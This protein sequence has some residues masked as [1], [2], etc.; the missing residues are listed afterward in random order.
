MTKLF[1]YDFDDQVRHHL[2]WVNFKMTNGKINTDLPDVL[3]GAPRMPH[4]L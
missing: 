1:H 4:H 3:L 2:W